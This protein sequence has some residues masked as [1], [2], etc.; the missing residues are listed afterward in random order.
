MTK[1]FLLL[2]LLLAGLSLSAQYHIAWVTVEPDTIYDDGN[3]TWSEIEVCIQDEF[4][5]P[6]N[7]ERVDF[8][9][10]HGSVLGYD[11]TNGLGIAETS[12]WE[13]DD[14]PGVAT[15]F[16]SVDNTILGEVEVTILEIV[17][18]DDDI[19]LISSLKNF[20]NP[21]R[22]DGSRGSGTD[23]SFSLTS[24]NRNDLNHFAEVLIYNIKGQLVRKLQTTTMLEDGFYTVHWDGK[25]E[26]GQSAESGVYLYA[27]TYLQEAYK[28]KMT[29]L[30]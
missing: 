28:G 21:F 18:A 4:N 26:S 15:I 9:T 2:L 22:V 17:S 10:N 16:I 23:I 25:K 29:L 8:D 12:F 14:G 20:P 7:G 3:L 27:I 6:V 30:K 1:Y 13:S 19:P 5:D 24:H 11:F